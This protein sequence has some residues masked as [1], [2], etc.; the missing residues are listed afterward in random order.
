TTDGLI[1]ELLKDPRFLKRITKVFLW[2]RDLYLGLARFDR[3]PGW[4]LKKT[5]DA[6][7]IY[8]A[9]EACD[10]KT[11]ETVHPWWA[12]KTTVKICPDSYR[13]TVFWLK[14]GR[15]CSGLSAQPEF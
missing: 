14:N 6:D 9:R 12:M 7:P 13:P 1:D 4:I 11:A 15:A 2:D 10:P 5:D 3:H 8:Y